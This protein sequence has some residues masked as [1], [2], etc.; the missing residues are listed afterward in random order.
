MGN[1]FD[2]I[3]RL[4]ELISQIDTPIA[5]ELNNAVSDV[6]AHLDRQIEENEQLG[7]SQADAIVRS[8]EIIVELEETKERLI[9]SRQEAEKAT[10]EAKLLSAFGDILEQSV[11]EFFIFDV[12]SLQFIHVNRGA[13]NNLGYSMDELR[14]MTPVDLQKR[15]SSASFSNLIEPLL[16]GTSDSID[17]TD[18]YVRKNGTEYPVEIHLSL[19]VLGDQDVFVAISLD[20]TN[21]QIEKEL[22]ESRERALAADRSKSEFLANMSH[23]IR[24]PM[25]A[26][27]GFNEILLENVSA[28]E[29]IDAA[30]TIKENGEYL[31]DIINDILDLSKVE[32]GKLEVEQ[33]KCSPHEI[34]AEVVSLMGVRASSKGLPLKV[35]FDGAVPRYII[36]DPTRIRQVLINLVGN[37]IKFTETGAVE[38]SVKLTDVNSTDPMLKIEVIDSGIGIS[39]SQKDKLFSPFTQAD[40]SMTR[41]FGGTGLGLAISCRLME[42]LGGKI[43]VSSKLGAGTVSLST[44]PLDLADLINVD[45]QQLEG[46]SKKSD[47]VVPQNQTL[48]GL[49]VLLVDDGPDNRRLINFILKKAGAE[50]CIAENGKQAFDLAMEAYDACRPFDVILMDMQMPVLDGYNATS[51]LRKHGYEGPIVALTAHAMETDRI[52]ALEAGCDDYVTK[53]IDRARLL[54]LVREIS[55]AKQI[56]DAVV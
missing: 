9:A 42:L 11:N 46:K 23:E 24:T 29:D 43:T 19:S 44:G 22:R 51:L 55:N 50:V 52:K 10:Q 13:I 48:V 53:P 7:K 5:A 36:S 38:I 4:Q 2:P 45:Q 8:A 18:V 27:L 30:R 41:K 17:F 56:T 39:D 40:N 34:I 14:Q 28:P 25:T 54:S 26:I 16:R 49:R 12:N 3:Q 20:I 21:R 37:A 32:A 33:V 6:Q 31:I 1:V 15:Q 47:E 35:R